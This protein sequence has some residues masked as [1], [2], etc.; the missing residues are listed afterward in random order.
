MRA[1]R[2]GFRFGALCAHFAVGASVV[3][4]LASHATTRPWAARLFRYWCGGVLRILNVRVRVS[5]HASPDPTLLAANH[6]SWLDIIVMANRV[7]MRFVAKQEI[8]QWPVVGAVA[9]RLGTL[10][11]ARGAHGAAEHVTQAM[12]Q[13]LAQGECVL[14]FP[15]GRTCDGVTLGRFF[16]RTFESALRAQRP[17][18]GVAIHYASSSGNPCPETPFVDEVEFLPHLWQLLG[19]ARIDASLA[20]CDV[21]RP[22]DLTRTRLARH[23][24]Q[25]VHAAFMWLK[26][27]P[28]LDSS[29]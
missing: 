17:V 15:E 23:V 7:P 26:T 18:Q 21:V 28:L 1:L 25:H 4:V 3:A 8:A 29:Y 24:E 5:G 16:P 19:V 13:I 12:T 6:I 22:L 20:F 11:I 14:V 9:R 27:Q 10:F 2:R